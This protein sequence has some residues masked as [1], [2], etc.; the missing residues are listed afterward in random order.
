VHPAD[1]RLNRPGGL[2]ERLFRARKAAG[3]RQD[4][5]ASALGWDRTKVSKIENGRQSP[6]E[7]D[8]RAWAQATGRPGEAPEL[9]ELLRDV[10]TVHTRWRRRLRGGLA[11]IQEDIGQ[12]TE[13]AKRIR[14]AELVLIPGLLQTAGYARAIIAQMAATYRA[15]DID[16]AVAARLRRQA[17]LYDQ[18]RTFEFTFTEAALRMF[19]CPPEVMGGQLDRLLSLDLPNVTIGIIPLGEVPL[20]PW[21]TFLMLDG[22]VIVETYGGQDEDAEGADFAV[23]E[24]IFDGLMAEA[25][26]GDE[27]RRLITAAA[28]DLRNS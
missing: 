22:D 11:G 21:Q 4:Q 26:T 12:R 2:A 17:V 25:A 23:H 9:V 28:A 20:M 8:L 10:E 1:E 6:S 18:D 19:P 13:A 27:A 7:D 5:L 3:L 16:A 15:T 24:R 14:N